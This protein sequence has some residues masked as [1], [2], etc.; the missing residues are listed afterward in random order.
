MWRVY[1]IDAQNPPPTLESKLF[2]TSWTTLMTGRPPPQAAAFSSWPK[3][4]VAWPPPWAAVGML[5]LAT[6]R[7]AMIVTSAA[8]FMP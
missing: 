7:I 1:P 3:L 5:Q 6:D 2:V 8:R 4:S